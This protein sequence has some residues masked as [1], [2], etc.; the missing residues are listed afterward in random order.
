MKS[1]MQTLGKQI[2]AIAAALSEGETLSAKGLLHLGSREAIDQ[3]LSRMVK[4]NTLMRAGRGLYVRPVSG[5]FGPRPPSPG[6]VIEALAAQTGE[7][8]APS[9]AAAANALGLTTQV[10][11][12][13]VYLTSGKG[14]VL[15]LG[16]H[17]VTLQHAPAWQTILPRAKAGQVIRALGWLGRPNAKGA[18]ATLKGKLGPA[19]VQELLGLRSQ[20]PTWLASEISRMATS[21]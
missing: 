7:R 10:P 14:R 2:G 20:V 3:A 19:E 4:Q 17:K 11:I 5:K 18:I 13:E 12:Q 21:A 15:T 9:G 6:K 1:E 8:I 16:N